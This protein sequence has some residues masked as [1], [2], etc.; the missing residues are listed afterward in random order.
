LKNQNGGYF[1]KIFKVYFSN[2]KEQTTNQMKNIVAI[3]EKFKMAAESNMATK[4]LFLF[5]IM[6]KKIVIF[7]IFFC[8]VPTMA[9]NTTLTETHFPWISK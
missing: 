9:K 5:H 1:A 7:L 8:C 2:N 6:I 3:H 4:K